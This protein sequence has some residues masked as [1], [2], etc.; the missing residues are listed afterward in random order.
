MHALFALVDAGHVVVPAADLAARV[1]PDELVAL[2][3]EGVVRRL[4]ASSAVLGAGAVEEI[5]LTGLVNALRDL[6]DVDA[7]GLPAP[8]SLSHH[9]VPIGWIGS[10]ADER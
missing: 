10:G 8:G 3:S 1:A 9:P 7:R 4:A 6:Y 2:R 5:S